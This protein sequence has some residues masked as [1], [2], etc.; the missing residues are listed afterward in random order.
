MRKQEASLFDP[1][2]AIFVGLM[3]LLV[4]AALA[5]C[6][7]GDGSGEE[8]S[9]GRQ[10]ASEDQAEVG[11]AVESGGWQVELTGLSEKIAMIGDAEIV[12]QAEEGIFLVVP[13]TLSNVSADMDV[14]PVSL[15]IVQDAQGVEYEP[16]GS[17]IQIAYVL[18][19][20]G[21]IVMDTPMAAGDKRVGY[22]VYDIPLEAEGLSLRVGDAAETIA[23]GF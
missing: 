14:P 19:K 3:C 8:G 9:G 1:G 17:T 15:F 7:G 12:Y 13:V 11:K 5:G 16:T 22:V 18:I 23:L 20:S 10:L 2:R 4:I 21:D 6:G